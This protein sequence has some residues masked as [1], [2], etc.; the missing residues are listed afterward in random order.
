VATT[1]QKYRSA[2][3]HEEL[4]AG[5][6]GARLVFVQTHADVDE[7]IR[8]DWRR[9]L[10]GSFD[11]G[12]IF[13]VDSVGA[14]ADIQAGLKPRGDFARLVDFLTRELTGAAAK[15][16]RR[17][18]FLD[19][20]ADTLEACRRRGAAG[21][22]ALAQLEAGLAEQRNRLANRLTVQLRDELIH[23]RRTWEHRLLGEAANRWGFSPFSWALRCFHG[24]GGLMASAA[25]WRVRS[26]AQLALWGAVEGGRQWRRRRLQKR[27]DVATAR[28][29]AEG[30]DEA[31][32]RTACIVVDGYA[33][34]A[35]LPREEADF[36]TVA[37]QA[38]EAGN[39]F[40]ARA[41]AELQLL[42]GRLADRHTGWFTRL[43][44]ETALVVVLALLL[45]R[46]GRNFFFDSWLAV[47][48]GYRAAPADVLG[49]D[50]FVQ[51]GFWLAMWCGVLLV[52]FTARL[53]RG[54]SREISGLAQSWLG[55]KV[56][57]GLFAGY[58]DL[59]RAIGRHQ[60]ELERLA[61]HVQSLRQHVAGEQ[62]AG[63][64]AAGLGSRKA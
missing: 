3:V 28:A 40:V 35:G 46:I 1:Q 44:Y 43:R 8:D 52:F 47:D 21:L 55:A 2:R 12:E 48:F 16:I 30:W 38:S 4:A 36:K 42:L 51:A 19:L 45:Y 62:G 54:M 10:A 7:E 27:A 20:V 33:A 59:S 63:A 26:T 14:L 9:M 56:A 18:N 6:A 41:G 5:A 25:L 61:Q 49:L 64:M 50:F 13:F 11:L 58:D 23:N 60:R 17:A 32:L 29:V 37:R 22:P 57:A 34:E 39:Q 53:R 24:L 31:E 15:R